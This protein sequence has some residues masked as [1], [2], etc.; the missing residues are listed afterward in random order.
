MEIG[1]LL[2]SRLLGGSEPDHRFLLGICG[3][4]GAGKSTL[5]IGLSRWLTSQGIEAR[6]YAGDWRFSLDS[7]A[8]KVWLNESLGS[9]LSNYLYAINQFSWWNFSEIRTDL[10]VLRRGDALEL[11]EAYNRASGKRDLG[12]TLGAMER[13]VIIYENA[14]LGGSELLEGMD[15]IVLVNTPD[16]DCLA[17]TLSR[18]SVRRNVSEIAARYLVTSY[19][20]NHFLH[21]LRQRYLA[22][23]IC[24]RDDGSLCAFPEIAPV[25]DIPVPLKVFLDLCSSPSVSMGRRDVPLREETASPDG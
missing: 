12:V 4:A 3:R 16:A 14:I 24:C 18:D 9:G 7:V 13:G 1:E 21:M 20:E 8:R 22:R 23:T 11:R 19:S 10:E 25:G 6:V 2:R 15:A 5:A 17:R